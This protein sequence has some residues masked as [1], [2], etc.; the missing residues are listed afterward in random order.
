VLDSSSSLGPPHGSGASSVLGHCPPPCL[1]ASPPYPSRRRR[2]DRAARGQ[3]S[4]RAA[5][6]PPTVFPCLPGVFDPARAAPPSPSRGGPGC[7]PRPRVR[8]ASAP[9]KAPLSGLPTLPARSPVNTSRAPLP[10]PAHDSG[11]AWVAHPALAGTFTLQHCA[12]LSRHTLTPAVS[13]ARKLKRSVGWRQS[14]A[15]PCSAGHAHDVAGGRE[16]VRSMLVLEPCPPC[17][18]G[19]LYS[20]GA[21][22]RQATHCLAAASLSQGMRHELWP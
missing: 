3:A 6:G 10:G 8:S 21:L 9:E 11:P 22:S 14:A 15:A 5:R 4:C 17:S 19:K 13:R 18:A 16:T 1:R 12:G 20:Q 2:A 7:L